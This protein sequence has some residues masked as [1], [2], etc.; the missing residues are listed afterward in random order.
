VQYTKFRWSSAQSGWSGFPV[1]AH[2]LGP[3]E[4]LKDFRVEDTLLWL[5]VAG[6]AKIEIGCGKQVHRVVS[7]PGT[8]ILLGRGYEQKFMEWSGTRELLCVSISTAELERFVGHDA[9]PAFRAID[10]QYAI[11][12]PQI[13]RLVLN[14]REEI[15]AGCPAGELYGESLS[16]ALAGYLLGR[17]SHGEQ[18]QEGLGNTLSASQA[19]RLRDYIHANLGH[20]LGLA[21]LANLVGLSPHHFS[22][23]FKR[24]F[25]IAPHHYLLLERIDESQKLLAERRLSICE[26]ALK[27]G[28]A[29]QSHFTQVFRKM[30]GTT[31]K[32]Y[33]R[34][35]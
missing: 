27:L 9:D 30:T 4:C 3:S 22:L 7:V 26:V 12:D 13:V 16:L 18:R 21:E 5:C 10:P 2:Q 11:S 34:R 20:D 14:M 25:G 19:Q 23:L 32:C 8:F 33:Q 35:R 29:D 31:P 17:Y 24:T 28:F 15:E 6:D 1:E